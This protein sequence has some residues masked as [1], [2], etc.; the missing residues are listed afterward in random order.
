MIRSKKQN[1]GIIRTIFSRNFVFP[2]R[3]ERNTTTV[4]KYK[5]VGKFTT[6]LE[7]GR[8][9]DVREYLVTGSTRHV[10]NPLSEYIYVANN[11]ERV[12]VS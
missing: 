7:I 11:R 2:I 12:T 10:R 5:G 9:G 8:G 1:V 4:T 6:K 3:N